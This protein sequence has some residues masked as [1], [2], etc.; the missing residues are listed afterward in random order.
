M[1]KDKNIKLYT[2]NVDNVDIKNNKKD[3]VSSR[4]K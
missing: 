2:N 3:K 4:D 1:A